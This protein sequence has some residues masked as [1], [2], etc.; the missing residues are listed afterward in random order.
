M[1]AEFNSYSGYVTTSTLDLNSDQLPQEYGV[2]LNAAD[3]CDA[4]G[5]RA[6][7]RYHLKSGV[8][9]FCA[10]HSREHGEPL[11]AS[12]LHVHDESESLQGS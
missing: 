8:L 9:M 2:E 5:A 3:R 1:K 7:V 10:H 12:A 6:Y 11:R 4:C